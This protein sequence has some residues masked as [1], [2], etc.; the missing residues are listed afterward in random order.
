MLGTQQVNPLRE[1]EYLL[2]GMVGGRGNGWSRSLG[3]SRKRV[4]VSA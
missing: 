1:V 4:M 3:S 2:V